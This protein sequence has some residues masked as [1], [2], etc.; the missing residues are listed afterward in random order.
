MTQSPLT[1]P[2]VSLSLRYALNVRGQGPRSRS[3]GRTA[4]LSL[5]VQPVMEMKRKMTHFIS[6]QNAQFLFIIQYNFFTVQSVQHVSDPYFGT[7]IRDPKHVGL[8][9]L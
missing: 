5:I 4:A 6:Q 2:A 1:P 8:I 9:L 7:I 3:Y